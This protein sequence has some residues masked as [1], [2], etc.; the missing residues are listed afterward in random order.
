MRI[1][2]P[3]EDA[4]VF[5]R[6][7]AARSG[8][9]AIVPNLNVMSRLLH[10][11]GFET[12]I[13]ETVGAGQGDT[14]IYGLVDVLIVLLQPETGDE[15]QWEKAGLL[16]VADIVVV[17]KADLPGADDV[18]SQVRELLN[19]P[20]CRSVPIL[21]ASAAKREGLRELWK[22]ILRSPPHQRR[23]TGQA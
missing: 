7:L 18:Q 15:L 16:E 17:H 4:G 20:G 10:G 9:Q 3:A 22:A 19:M 2:K 21:K 5:V 14:A 12:V 1:S 6:S 11:F 8:Q 13:I 23:I